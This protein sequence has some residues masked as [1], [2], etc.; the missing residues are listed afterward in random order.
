M[1]GKVLAQGRFVEWLNSQAEVV[2]IPP[3]FTRRG[4]ADAPELPADGHQVDEGAPGAELN[5]ADLFLVALH[6]AAEGL[7][8]EPEHLF[9]LD[10]AKDEMI[11]I[12]EVKHDRRLWGGECA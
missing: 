7:A 2:Q 11:D 4:T 8:V 3:L 5:E 6:G 9:Q 12:D 1:P 10:D